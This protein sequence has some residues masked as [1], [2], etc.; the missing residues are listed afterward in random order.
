MKD[1]SQIDEQ[2]DEIL[3][4]YIVFGQKQQPFCCARCS[5]QTDDDT[6]TFCWCTDRDSSSRADS[7]T[8][9]KNIRYPRFAKAKGTA[10]QAIHSLLAQERQR[11]IDKLIIVL[12]NHI[13]AGD[14]EMKHITLG[15]ILAIFKEQDK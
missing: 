14:I 8:W 1:N 5:A 15:Q 3:N 13:V 4:Q 6:E 7:P 9:I 10:R 11:V 2:I 12:A